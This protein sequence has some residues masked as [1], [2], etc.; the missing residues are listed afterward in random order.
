MTRRARQLSV[1]VE[2][3]T[4][5]EEHLAELDLLQGNPNRALRAYEKVVEETGNPEL[6]GA[7]ADAYD[8]VGRTEEA[9]AT[10]NRATEA[11][12]AQIKSHGS[13]IS[14]HAIEYF[15]EHGTPEQIQRFIPA[16]LTGEIFWCQLFSEPEAGSDLAALR[17]KAVKVD[18][19]WKLTGQKVWITAVP[20]AHKLLVVARSLRMP[21]REP[22]CIGL[23]S[24]SRCGSKPSS[25]LVAVIYASSSSNGMSAMTPCSVPRTT[26]NKPPSSPSGV[27][28]SSIS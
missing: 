24:R 12:E 3:A 19:G 10:R 1:T 8:A 14:G 23:I 17:T 25:T 28:C 27:G 15:L 7:L 13:L 22:R 18:G 21:P 16:T 11:F 6:I 20:Q 26:T 5:L 2:V 4:D 9:T